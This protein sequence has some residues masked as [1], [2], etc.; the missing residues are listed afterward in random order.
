ADV[1]DH[2]AD[3]FVDRQTG[4]DHGGDRLLD[5]VGLAGAGGEG[6]VFHRAFFDLGD[7]ARDA[8]DDAGVGGHHALQVDLADEVVEHHLDGVEVGDDAVLEG[9]DG[10]DALRGLADHR[11]R[12]DAH[13]EGPA[14]LSIDGDDGGLGDDDP[15]AADVDEGVGG[16]E[17]D[18]QVAAEDTE[19]GGQ[20]AD[21][22]CGFPEG[23]AV[24]AGGGLRLVGG[25]AGRG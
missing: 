7:A 8:D 21:H 23:P 2:A 3:R 10:D 22:G 6:G 12:F 4:A 17:V 20:R 1:D 19:Q 16:P 9:A 25:G 14:T 11:F 15:L 13:G 18:P 5:R 24:T